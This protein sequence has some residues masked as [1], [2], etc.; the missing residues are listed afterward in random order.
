MPWNLS[1]FTFER[2]QAKQNGN[3]FGDGAEVGQSTSAQ[4]LGW[5]KG[6]QAITNKLQD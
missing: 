6:Y 1:K 2:F 3:I 4:F 5:E